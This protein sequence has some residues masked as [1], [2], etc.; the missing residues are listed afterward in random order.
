MEDLKKTQLGLLVVKIKCPKLKVFWM[1][2]LKAFG[3]NRLGTEEEKNSEHKDIE[4]ETTSK[5][6]EKRL[7]KQNISELWN[8]IRWDA[9][10]AFELS[11]GK[12]REKGSKN[13]FE[14]IIVKNF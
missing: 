6:T 1:N 12:E 3:Y 4:E 14:D 11:E 13:I 5:H 10:C 8:S 9:A 7:K 2:K